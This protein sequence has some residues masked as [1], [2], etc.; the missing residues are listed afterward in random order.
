MKSIVML[1]LIVCLSIFNL[2]AQQQVQKEIVLVGTM[3]KVPKIVKHSYKPMLRR[4]KKYNPT[5]IYVESPKGNDS[6]SWAYLKNGWSKSYKQ[7]Y[8]LSDSIKNVFTPDSTKV[9]SLLE[10]DFSAM[11]KQDLQYLQKTFAYHRDDANFGFYSYILKH[12]LKGSKKPTRYEDGDLTYKLA[13]HQNIKLLNAMD[14]QRTNDKYH[15]GWSKCYKEG[16]NNGNNAIMKKLN[17]KDYNSAILPAIF[18]GLGKHTNKKKSLQTS[19]QLAAFTYTKNMT[20]G[21]KQGEKYWN[22]R[23][24]RMAKNIGESVKASD[25]TRNIVIVGAA[26][27]IGLEKELKENYPQFKTTLVNEL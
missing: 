22:E 6:L 4:A 13:I 20:D 3:H 8:H 17:K 2:N 21:C 16:K 5:A 27:I 15:E 14:D 24:M 11:T 25:K 7:F 9:L 18:R 1:I 26:H 12:G 23:N 10:K 19:H